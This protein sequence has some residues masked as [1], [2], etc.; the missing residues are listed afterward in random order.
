M[1]DAGNE[2]YYQGSDDFQSKE[3]FRTRFIEMKDGRGSLTE[4]I[5][6]RRIFYPYSYEVPLLYNDTLNVRMLFEYVTSAALTSINPQIVALPSLESDCVMAS[7][8][9]KLYKSKKGTD[10]ILVAED[11]KEFAVHRTV[12]HARSDYFRAMLTLDCKEAK[13]GRCPVLDVNAEVLEVLLLFMYGGLTEVPAQLAQSV[14]IASDKY[15]FPVLKDHCEGLLMGQ[16]MLGTAAHFLILADK[17]S[18]PKLR[19]ACLKMITDGFEVFSE[20]GGMKKLQA[21]GNPDLLKV[22]KDMLYPKS[23][24]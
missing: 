18:A 5:P 21:D 22:V 16:V 7:D 3:T 4:D 24:S 19:E 20:A 2:V 17:Y 14:L 10:F 11:G 13:E 23:P 6:S 9:M 12:L 1:D 8:Y 15:Q